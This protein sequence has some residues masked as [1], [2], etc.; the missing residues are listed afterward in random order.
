MDDG[1]GGEGMRPLISSLDVGAWPRGRIINA[2]CR[3]VDNERHLLR[4]GLTGLAAY[5]DFFGAHS[6]AERAERGGGG[7][8]RLKH[9][10]LGHQVST[11]PL[12]DV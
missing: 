12:I 8:Q 2:L 1:V 3:G 7:E 9:G 10:A 4:Y 11:L 5:D 6:A